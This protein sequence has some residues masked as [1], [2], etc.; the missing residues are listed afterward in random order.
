MP[1]R[2]KSRAHSR[3]LT[4]YDEF[5]GVAPRLNRLPQ[6]LDY[7]LIPAPLD[8]SKPLVDEKSE[9]P[10]IIV[11]PSS[12]VF[13]SKFF[14]AFIAPP[15]SPTFSQ[16]LSS[17][18]PSFRSYLPSQI[19]LPQTPFKTTFNDGN[20]SFS[21]RGRIRTIILLFLLLFIMASHVVIHRIATNHPHLQ[22]G[23]I[24]DNDI[25]VSSL[26]H[27]GNMDVFG[28]GGR[29]D[30]QDT[31][32]E[33]STAGFWNLRALWA[34]TGATS[35]RSFIVVEELAPKEGNDN[36]TPKEEVRPEVAA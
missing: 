21:L 7:T 34:P 20:N 1:H 8:L 13:E 27:T 9:L 16:R 2:R 28:V 19:Q 10:A 29:A 31:T 11:T 33:P 4:A 17:L 32:E 23:I 25:D 14:I 18:V 24:P 22:F 12:P 15:P 5:H 36:D 6:R 26:S 30:A 35:S 3:Y